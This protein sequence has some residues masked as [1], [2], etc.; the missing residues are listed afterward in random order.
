MIANFL[1]PGVAG[2][3]MSEMG[4]SDA[5]ATDSHIY[6]AGQVGQ[7]AD[8][9]TPPSYEEQARLAFRNVKARVIEAGGDP[10]RIVALT[11]LMDQSLTSDRRNTNEILKEAKAAELPECSPATTGLF[12]AGLA[13]RR[14]L[15]EV[16][17]IVVR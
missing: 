12:V 5:V 4:F 16:Q 1:A 6:I 11:I 14:F 3:W 8:G 17:A 15:V 9:T 13:F 2:E 7:L 10:A